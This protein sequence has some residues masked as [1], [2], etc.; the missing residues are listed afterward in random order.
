LI[1]IDLL[2]IIFAW[3]KVLF[4][5]LFAVKLIHHLSGKTDV[6]AAYFISIIYVS[7][8]KKIHGPSLTIAVIPD[9]LL[10]VA[11]IGGYFK[12]YV[13]NGS[14]NTMVQIMLFLTL[15]SF[16]AILI[17]S[18]LVISAFFIRETFL[19]VALL[20]VYVTRKISF[21]L[22]MVLIPLALL[23]VVDVL[24]YFSLL[25][26]YNAIQTLEFADGSLRERY[27]IFLGY[28]IYRMDSAL[29][30]STGGVSMLYAYFGILGLTYRLYKRIFVSRI[31]G[32]FLSFVAIIS[33]SI[34]GL[35]VLFLGLVFFVSNKWAKVLFTAAFLMSVLA[36]QNLTLLAD[37]QET[38]NV[39]GYIVDNI[40]NSVS[41]LFDLDSSLLL[42]GEI[43]IKS[44]IID[45]R[46]TGRD[47]ALFSI[48]LNS[49]LLFFIVFILFHRI[50]YMNLLRYRGFKYALFLTLVPLLYPHSNYLITRPLEIMAIIPIIIFRDE[51]IS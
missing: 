50:L 42:G 46:G 29:T 13:K 20:Y 9:V 26:W 48:V 51:D 12:P 3:N 16:G 34:S 39:L 25:N 2:L 8:F 23:A 28:K 14:I 24:N 37:G 49:G 22:G 7:L 10:I 15:L 40:W 21:D 36:L 47:K 11:I 4:L 19:P 31:I 30:I 35:I 1:F 43:D 41:I 5:F 18:G 17:K 32:F 44:S 33:S 6:L 38:I 45:G 27:R